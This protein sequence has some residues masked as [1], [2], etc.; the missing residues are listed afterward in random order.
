MLNLTS[1]SS[2]LSYFWRCMLKEENGISLFTR[3][4]TKTDWKSWNFHYSTGY[5]L[6]LYTKRYT[7]AII[8][9]KL[10]WDQY[11]WRCFCLFSA[12]IIFYM[13]VLSTL[14]KSHLIWY[15]H[16]LLLYFWLNIHFIF[17]VVQCTLINTEF[18]FFR[19]QNFQLCKFNITIMKNSCSLYFPLLHLHLK[20]SQL[21]Y[22]IP[23]VNNNYHFFRLL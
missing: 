18:S 10:L 2:S 19:F 20:N 9:K 13:H 1:G 17:H 6:E 7:R 16:F 14:I 5:K 21:W 8:F 3:K 22:S 4:Y 12:G 15:I 11:H 23:L